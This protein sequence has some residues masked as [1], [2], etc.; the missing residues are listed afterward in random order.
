[1]ENRSD[2]SQ[3]TEARLA[4]QK[5]ATLF[6]EAVLP[7]LAAAYNLARWLVR[8]AHD[9][10]DLVQEAYLRAF[11]SFDGFHGEDSRAWLLAIV[12]NTCYTW[13][14]RNRVQ[15]LTTVFD[16]ER[17][18]SEDDACNP[19]ALLLKN[20][21][22]QLLR[23]ALEE[24]PLEFREAIILRELEGMTYKEIADLAGVPMGTVMSRLVRA[25]QRL[26]R[27]LAAPAKKES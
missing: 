17:H 5:R 20:A 22:A 24:Q 3:G 14:K 26:Q 16:E 23:Q 1:M 18:S 4:V 10:E 8:N 2:L 21:D 19:E 15:E 7:H 11:K 6:E 27:R 12:R 13:L 25:R 9:A